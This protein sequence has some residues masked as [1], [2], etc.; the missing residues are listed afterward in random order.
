MNQNQNQFYWTGM[1]AHTRNLTQIFLCSQCT[2]TERH[3][4]TAKN[5]DKFDKVNINI[6]LLCTCINIYE[7]YIYTVY[8]SIF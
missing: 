5:K 8:I 6:K 3:T 7:K 4:S 2:Y 1:C